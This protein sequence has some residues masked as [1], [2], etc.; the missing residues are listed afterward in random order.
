MS[1][2][3]LSVHSAIAQM[4]FK[5][6]LPPNSAKVPAIF[7]HEP[8]V[9][10]MEATLPKFEVFAPRLHITADDVLTEKAR[11]E[12]AMKK[13]YSPI[14]QATFGPLSQL[15]GYVLN[16]LSLLHP[17]ESKAAAAMLLREQDIRLERLDEAARL[18][19]LDAIGNPDALKEDLETERDMFVENRATGR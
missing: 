13:Y 17:G 3:K 9:V 15:A 6:E 5:F 16:P 4:G 11:T 1:E 10:E 12:N 19:H 14:Y 8:L 7:S 18:A 2:P